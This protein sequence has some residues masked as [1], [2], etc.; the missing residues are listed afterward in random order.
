MGSRLARIFA[1]G[2][3][4]AVIATQCGQ[5]NEDF[6]GEGNDSSLPLSAK[7]GGGAEEIRERGVFGEAKSAGPI[8]DAGFARRGE[9]VV[10]NASRACGGRY[11]RHLWLRSFSHP[12]PS[13]PLGTARMASG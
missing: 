6:F 11:R 13:A 10:D 1:E 2:A 8:V 12:Y 3:V 5:R 4:A 7:L 9:E